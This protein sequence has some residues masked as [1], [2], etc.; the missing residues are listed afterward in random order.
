MTSDDVRLDVFDETAM[1]NIR[2]NRTQ[3]TIDV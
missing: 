2:K 3:M 1:V